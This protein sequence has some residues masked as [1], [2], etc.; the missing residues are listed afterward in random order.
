MEEERLSFLIHVLRLI[1]DADENVAG[2]STA[3]LKTSA[4]TVGSA[5]PHSDLRLFLHNKTV[6]GM[7]RQ[8]ANAQ[9]LSREK[10]CC[11]PLPWSAR[12]GSGMIRSSCTPQQRQR[13]AATT[14]EPEPVAAPA[15]PVDTP[16]SSGGGMM[17]M[18]SR[19]RGRDT[20]PTT[21]PTAAAA[22]QSRPTEDDDDDGDDVVPV[23]V[24]VYA[25]SQYS[26]DS[27]RK[28]EDM[29]PMIDAWV[30]A[31]F[32][33]K[34]SEVYSENRSQTPVPFA[35][36][37]GKG[38]EGTGTAASSSSAEGGE[39]ACMIGDAACG[40][41]GVCRLPQKVQLLHPPVALK[42]APPRHR[43]PLRVALPRLARV[44]SRSMAR[45]RW[46]FPQTT[47]VRCS[48]SRTWMCCSDT[49]QAETRSCE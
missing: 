29:N 26:A 46:S 17:S 22:A 20:T 47:A 21:T 39:C 33:G 40:V 37:E 41:D 10:V 7:L 34:G 16:K 43:S 4:E 14:P 8:L 49:C 13:E 23:P 15:V 45:W 18:F 42:G 2:C 28:S 5:Y 36:G 6:D 35:E 19:A 11:S 48:P 24:P 25:R 32:K 27:I 12:L 31:L 1:S 44:T 9:R 30:D 3:D 38:D